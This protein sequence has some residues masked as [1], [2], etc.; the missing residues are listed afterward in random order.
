MRDAMERG[1]M[2]RR[3]SK[4]RNGQGCV[5]LASAIRGANGTIRAPHC[6]AGRTGTMQH[7]IA[8]RAMVQDMT[9]G[10]RSATHPRRATCGANKDTV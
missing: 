1:V 9:E 6:D 7:A 2:E 10:E 3:D 8:R 4:A 5:L